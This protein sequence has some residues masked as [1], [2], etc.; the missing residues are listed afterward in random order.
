MAPSA[1]AAAR[2][3]S[4]AVSLRCDPS[5][6]GQGLLHGEP[7]TYVGGYHLGIETIESDGAGIVQLDAGG[8]QQMQ[9]GTGQGGLSV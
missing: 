8:M 1:T 6:A 5:G 7:G 4:P 2:S 9:D 3:A